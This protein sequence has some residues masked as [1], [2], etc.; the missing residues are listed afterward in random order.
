MSNI[1]KRFIKQSI[2]GFIMGVVVCLLIIFIFG[3]TSPD[4][5]ITLV[6]PVF[7]EHVG[8]LVPAFIIQCILSGIIGI[9]G[10]GGAVMYRI[11]NWSIL[12]ATL[13]HFFV[14]FPIYIAVSIILRWITLD[15]IFSIIFVVGLHFVAYTLIWLIQYFRVRRQVKDMNKGLDGLKKEKKSE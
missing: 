1:L 7:A 9:A 3:A 13:T 14:E 5:E 12:R 2:I 11:E 8:G 4:D 10:F 6:S 15:D